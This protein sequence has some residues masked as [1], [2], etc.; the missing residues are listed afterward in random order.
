MLKDSLHPKS[1]RKVAMSTSRLHSLTPLRIVGITLA[2]AGLLA[3]PGCWVLSVNPLYE[4]DLSDVTF[5]ESLVG[6]WGRMDDNCLWI[7]TIAAHKP[8][9]ELTMSH[10]AECESK[11][12]P[13]HYEGHLVR[14]D[15]HRFLDIT[16]QSDEVCSLCLPMHEFLLTTQENDTLSFVELDGDWIKQEM[17]E[18][19]VRLAHF[20]GR[21]DFESVTLTG[22][23][24]E[25]KRFVRKYADNKAAFKPDPDGKLKFKKR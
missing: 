1:G 11:E 17:K 20:G 9:Y 13:T 24:K 6:S 8:A 2:L 3:L 15:N 5:D 12:K 14:L 22:S 7:L 25:L 4:E 10:A 18:K 21:R 16:P 23:P 19:R